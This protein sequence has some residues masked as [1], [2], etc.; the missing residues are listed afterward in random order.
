MTTQDHDGTYLAC[1]I[2]SVLTSLL[3][4]PMWTCFREPLLKL[5]SIS[6]IYYLL[7][8]NNGLQCA[9]GIRM[10]LWAY[11]D[12]SDAYGGFEFE[13]VGSIQQAIYFQIIF[14]IGGC[15]GDFV[16]KYGGSWIM[17]AVPVCFKSYLVSFCIGTNWYKKST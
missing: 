14:S 7:N 2:A 3:L 15:I 6:N 1:G 12:E 10:L 11:S 17:E 16:T 13:G 4:I 9:L 5:N 8:I